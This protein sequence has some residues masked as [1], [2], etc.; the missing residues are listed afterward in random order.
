MEFGREHGY[1]E[2][3]CVLPESSNE[4]YR[5]YKWVEKVHS[6]Y[7]AFKNGEP[8]GFLND[9]RVLQ[10]IKIGFEFKNN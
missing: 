5:L 1:F 7:E 4:E 2:V 8:S 9:E 10:L 6:D 3:P